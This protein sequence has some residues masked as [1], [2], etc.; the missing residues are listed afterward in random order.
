[1]ILYVPEIYDQVQLSTKPIRL[2][3]HLGGFD[4]NYNCKLLYN[5]NQMAKNKNTIQTIILDQIIE[6]E[7]AALY[8]YLDIKQKFD[9]HWMTYATVNMGLEKYAQHPDLNF[10][11]FVCSF[12]GSAH[13]GRKLCVAILQKFGWFKPGYCTKNFTFDTDTLDGHIHDYV[14]SNEQFYRKFFISD[15]SENFFQT[16]HSIDYVGNYTCLDDM[17]KL[18][19]AMTQSF[20]QIVVEPIATSYVPLVSEK[21]LQRILTRGLFVSYAPP[22]WHDHLVKYYGFQKYDK[23]FNYE[24][25]SIKNPIVRLVELI[26]MISKFSV[27]SFA[28][29]HDLYRLEQDKI[30]YNYDHYRSGR[31][32]QHLKQYETITK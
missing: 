17:Y 14:G 22:G 2:R 18:E 21:I 16:I 1:M 15:N 25:D 20:L 24:F 23:L 11:N 12:N 28:D 30:E 8:P 3:D 26:S 10:K 4:E 7:V 6:P 5:I 13:V 29:W 19:K 9:W 31:Y 27:L 32:L